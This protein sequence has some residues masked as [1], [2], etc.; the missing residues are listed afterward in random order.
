M[1]RGTFWSTGQVIMS[2][3]A[4]I[5]IALWELKGKRLGV[6]IYDLLGGATRERARV[7]R[8]LAGATAEELLEDALRW[9]ER[10]FTALRFGPLRAFDDHSLTHWDP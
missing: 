2:A 6:P 3:V 5:D 10:G 9:Q 8:H 1:V 7:Y 4:G